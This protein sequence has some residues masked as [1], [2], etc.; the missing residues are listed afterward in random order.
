MVN[1]NPQGI[2]SNIAD[3][4]RNDEQIRKPSLTMS[5]KKQKSVR[6]QVDD[7]DDSPVVRESVSELSSESFDEVNNRDDDDKRQEQPVDEDCQDRTSVDR[8]SE[9]TEE[10][11]R[12]LD[13]MKREYKMLTG[14]DFKLKKGQ[15]WKSVIHKMLQG[16][17]EKKGADFNKIDTSSDQVESGVEGRQRQEQRG[18]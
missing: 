16:S 17:G 8:M 14:K 6:F 3:V 11:K 18:G 10:E 12:A 9:L 1:V 15:D 13:M 2:Q 7:K 5:L 4:F